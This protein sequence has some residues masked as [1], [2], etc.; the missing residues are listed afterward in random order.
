V[1]AAGFADTS[2]VVVYL[3]NANQ[4]VVAKPGDVRW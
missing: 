2:T 3:G 4:L 1:T